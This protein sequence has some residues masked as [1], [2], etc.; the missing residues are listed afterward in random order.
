MTAVE[1]HGSPAAIVGPT[2][3]IEVLDPSQVE[4]AVDAVLRDGLVVLPGVLGADEVATIRK[5]VD[6][7]SA[8]QIAG[9]P[10]EQAKRGPSTTRSP[11]AATS[12]SGRS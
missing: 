9:M 6:R 10:F 12:R 11:T 2:R 8:R 3:G 1:T 4:Q 7:V 5:A